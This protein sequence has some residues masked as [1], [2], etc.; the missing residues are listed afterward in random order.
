MLCLSNVERTGSDVLTLALGYGDG[1]GLQGLGVRS[2]SE[3]G[4]GYEEKTCMLECS[5]FERISLVTFSRVVGSADST[6]ILELNV[7][8]DTSMTRLRVF[9]F[10]V[11]A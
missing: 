5:G 2:L 4:G 10:V 1:H 7:V 9:S 11:R 6:Y 3:P 8:D